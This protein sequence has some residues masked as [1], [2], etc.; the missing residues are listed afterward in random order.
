MTRKIN[1]QFVFLA[2]SICTRVSNLR[3]IIIISCVLFMAIKCNANCTKDFY[4][5][6]YEYR[7]DKLQDSQFVISKAILA[8]KDWVRSDVGRHAVIHFDPK[9]YMLTSLRS[10][11]SIDLSNC[12]NI[13][14]S[15]IMCGP[16]TT[17]CTRL[18]GASPTL[19]TKQ[20][21]LYNSFFKIDHANHITIE[22]FF[23]DKASPYFTQ[24][25]VVGVH[26]NKKSIDVEI[27][28]GYPN[29]QDPL[30]AK[31]YKVAVF[32]VGSNT[33]FWTHSEG[34]CED[35]NSFSP[36]QQCENFHIL[37]TQHE[38]GRIWQLNLNKPFRGTF[39]RTK[40]LVWQN[41]GWQPGFLIADSKDVTI[42]NIFY[43]GGGGSAVHV[44]QSEGNIVIENVNVD[45]PPGSNRLFA[46]TSGFNGSSNR[47]TITLDHVSVKH[48]DDDA[49][50]FSAGSY[51][52]VLNE[53]SDGRRIR[54]DLCYE[55]QFKPGDDIAA[56]NWQKKQEVGR[57]QVQSVSIVTDDD[58]KKYRRTCD[59]SLDRALPT[60]QNLRTYS[61]KNLGIQHDENDRILN[62]SLHAFLTVKNS[63]LSSM[64]ARC[65]IVQVSALIENNV[66]A[67]T[68]AAGLL[69]GPEYA[70]GEGYSVNGVKIINNVF[71]SIGGTA[72]YIADIDDSISSPTAHEM[73]A[74]TTTGPVQMDNKNITVSGNRF[75]HL[76]FVASG[77]MGIRGAAVTV[78]NARNVTISNNT[79]GTSRHSVPLAADQLIVAP[80]STAAV[81]R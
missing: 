26:D 61:E 53:S 18:I 14:L 8:A 71:D 45:I 1:H 29:F 25:S 47:G 59:I 11:F 12:T 58:P 81:T 32:F 54:V 63:Y 40:V 44:Q 30:I 33:P 65:G 20:L 46:A 56:W 35:V 2:Y 64:R 50:H 48:T 17:K 76:G 51:F 34:T 23:L 80:A 66:C 78:A 41:L 7:N 4:V 13:T 27:D 57:A 70:W 28:D 37:S 31:F 21:P 24:G 73:L 39:R 10:L 60:L 49:F 38:N 67:N 79:Y 72:V 74:R 15:G 19:N 22:N 55:G 68:P 16:V 75:N 6:D 62:L 69:V 77:I 52:P 36:G 42:R 9:T 5:H 3:Y 43:T